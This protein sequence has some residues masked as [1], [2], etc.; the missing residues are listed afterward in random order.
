MQEIKNMNE[1]ECII[2]AL[3]KHSDNS[4]IS[5][6]EEIGTN[7]TDELIRELT[8]K[9]L[10]SKNTHDSLKVVLI[11]NGKG[12]HDLNDQV[13]ESAISSLMALPDKTEAIRILEDTVNMH[14]DEIVRTRANQVKTILSGSQN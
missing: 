9:A 4:A 6:L 11:S 8:V 7:S 2:E 3:G 12:I 5:V 14:S 13:S 10:V 1:I